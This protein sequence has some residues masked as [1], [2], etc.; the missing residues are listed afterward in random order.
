MARVL[1]SDEGIIAFWNH[2]P[3]DMSLGSA[4]L[5][6]AFSELL[7]RTGRGYATEEEMRSIARDLEPT[8]ARMI[9]L[10][11]FTREEWLIEALLR[12]S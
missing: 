12:A 4:V 3:D 11:L 1:S 5:G 8:A 7:A 2:L 9:R 10:G 6:V